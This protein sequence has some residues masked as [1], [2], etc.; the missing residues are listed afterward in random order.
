MLFCMLL[1]SSTDFSQKVFFFKNF[2]EHY[3]SVKRFESISTD[4][5]SVLIWIQTI[6]EGYQQTTKVVASKEHNIGH[7][8]IQCVLVFEF[9]FLYLYL[10]F[11]LSESALATSTRKCSTPESDDCPS[12]DITS[13]Q[14]MIPSYSAHQNIHPLY[15]NR[16]HKFDSNFENMKLPAR[17]VSNILNRDSNSLNILTDS[18]SSS[19]SPTDE[20]R[21]ESDFV[22]SDI[23]VN[24]MHRFALGEDKSLDSLGES[25]QNSPSPMKCK[26]KKTR[27]VFSR[28]QIYQ[29]ENAFE[30]KRYLSSAERSGL[31]TR[32]QLS[33]TQIKIWFQN[34][35]NK[36][37]RQI[38][39]EMDEIPIPP[40]AL[41][42]PTGL[43]PSPY[44]S[45]VSPY[46][47]VVESRDAL[48]RGSLVSSA[49]AFYSNPYVQET[50]LR[51]SFIS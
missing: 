48:L 14:P 39:G 3:L 36:W 28:S 32:L 21:F 13:V 24:K 40:Y 34:R 50:R 33:E 49:P 45:P 16:H 7:C 29:L 42:S 38:S 31:A 26:K 35:R 41:H 37:K 47:S 17:S 1:L 2:Q 15:L 46:G 51:P 6:C 27:T 30:M 22:H 4:V 5:L 9:V 12:P 20:K 19:P 18:Y 23:P 25:Y 43:L 10:C 8:L 11:L 44:L